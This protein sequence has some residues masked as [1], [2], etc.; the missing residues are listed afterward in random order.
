MIPC[1][2]LV[3]E[4]PKSRPNASLFDHHRVDHSSAN[5]SQST[6]VLVEL[7]AK[8]PEMNITGNDML[9]A[10]AI[11]LCLAGPLAWAFVKYWLF[12]L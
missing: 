10:L 1:P 7:G 11:A 5:P 8:V 4:A 6:P 12:A 2:D 3:A 9:L